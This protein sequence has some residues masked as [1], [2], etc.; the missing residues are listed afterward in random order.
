MD[1]HGLIQIIRLV[2]EMNADAFSSV[3]MYVHPWLEFFL[4]RGPTAALS[5]AFR[6]GLG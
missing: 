4:F 2:S 3:S 5:D 1:A 6:R